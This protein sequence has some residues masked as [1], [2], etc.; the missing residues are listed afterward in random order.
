MAIQTDLKIR[1]INSNTENPV[2]I[3]VLKRHLLGPILSQINSV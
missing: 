1:L 3:P 2:N